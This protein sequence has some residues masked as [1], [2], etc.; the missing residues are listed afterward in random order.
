MPN[1]WID[2]GQNRY[3]KRKRKPRYAKWKSLFCPRVQWFVMRRRYFTQN[4]LPDC[5][6]MVEKSVQRTVSCRVRWTRH[7]RV[8]NARRFRLQRF[9]LNRNWGKNF[10]FGFSARQKEILSPVS[11]NGRWRFSVLPLP[12]RNCQ[13]RRRSRKMGL[14]LGRR[15]P[16][17]QSCQRNSKR[18]YKRAKSESLREKRAKRT[19]DNVFGFA[20]I[21]T[22][23]RITI[24]MTWGETA[25]KP[26]KI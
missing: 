19:S 23:R 13:T 21:A 5:R 18:K 9:K 8:W 3:E 1:G 10:A 25:R 11:W 26:A 14:D 7:R 4:S 22:N 24:E 15:K 6:Q 20:P 16:K 17:M 2:A 12:D